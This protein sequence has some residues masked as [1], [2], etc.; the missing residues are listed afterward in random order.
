MLKTIHYT[1][2]IFLSILIFSCSNSNENQNPQYPYLIDFTGNYGETDI[3]LDSYLDHM[4]ITRLETNENTYLRNFT[5]FVSE[6][7]IISVDYDKIILFST[8]GKYLTSI[9][10]KGKGPGE[11]TQIDAW[12]VSDNEG[13]LY[14]HDYSK[15]YIYKYD[16][17][18]HSLENNIPFE[19]K[20]FLSSL[21]WMNDTTLAV[22]PS[23]FTNYGYLYFF[24]S[25]SGKILDGIEKE[26]VPHP[27]TWA[28]ASPIFTK[29]DNNSILFKPSESDTIFHIQ[30]TN[31]SPGI[32]LK[33]NKPQTTGD[34]TV[35][36]YAQLI[37]SDEDKMIL[38]KN[39]VEKTVT[40][41]SVSI[42]TLDNEYFLYETASQSLKKINEIKFDYNGIELDIPN[43]NFYQ[44]S[45]FWISMLA[46]D[47]K[48]LI[49]ENM[50]KSNRTEAEISELKKLNN[51]ISM[52]DNPVILS[53]SL[54][55]I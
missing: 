13:I 14:Y 32:V 35:E 7:C 15:N 29:K 46:I 25:T 43:L 24:Q 53:G 27:G 39:E 1:V 34:K 36:E 9:S 17:E 6:K 11:F 52:D 51:L 16:L 55:G 45:R 4:K 54:K 28:G 19:D 20:G 30:G 23:L 42:K 50:A 21:V 3:N 41:M 12:T 44:N 18:K 22:L 38:K 8:E 40:E 37:Y 33:L 49:E 31:M 48:E 2:V 10:K 47:F 26:P 5:G